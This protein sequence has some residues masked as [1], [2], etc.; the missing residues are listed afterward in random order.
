[1][2][3]VIFGQKLIF[4]NQNLKWPIRLNDSLVSRFFST[5]HYRIKSTNF[6]RN[7]PFKDDFRLI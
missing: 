7:R 5:Y 6:D 2:K 4:K 3:L 1:M